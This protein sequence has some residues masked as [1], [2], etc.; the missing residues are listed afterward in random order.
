MRK[1]PHGYLGHKF[2]LVLDHSIK[3]RLMREIGSPRGL[4]IQT[5]LRAVV[6]P[7][8]FE[9]KEWLAS[10]AFKEWTAFNERRRA[11][12]GTKR[13]RNRRRDV[14]GRRRGG[15]DRRR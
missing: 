10:D 3:K 2:M 8:W 11:R 5:V 12:L 9:F 1:G 15:A 14:H 13:R 7:E 4:N 6:I